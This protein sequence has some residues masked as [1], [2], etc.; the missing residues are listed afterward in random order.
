[1][2]EEDEWDED[3][4]C[5]QEFYVCGERLEVEERVGG[6]VGPEGGIGGAAEGVVEERGVGKLEGSEG[7]VLAVES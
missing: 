5:A 4:A 6:E 3:G 1:M 2:R 7:Y